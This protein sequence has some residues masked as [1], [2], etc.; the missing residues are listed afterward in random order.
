MLILLMRLGKRVEKLLNG[1]Y[2]QENCV[3]G[4]TLS[5]VIL[6][7]KQ[8]EEYI[9]DKSLESLAFHLFN[10]EPVIIPK[11]DIIVGVLYNG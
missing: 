9:Y 1:K 11:D 7:D 2:H 4:G 10:G 3:Y 6:F 8:K 5:N